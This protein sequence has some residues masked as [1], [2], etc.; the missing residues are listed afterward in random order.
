MPG[1][2]IVVVPLRAVASARRI[3]LGVQQACSVVIVFKHEMNMPA[4]LRGEIADNAAEI[5]QHRDFAELGDGVHGV[6]PQPVETVFVQP[7]QRILDGEGAHLRYPIIDRAAPGGLRLRE[8][9]RR[10]AAEIISLGTEVIVDHVEKH[11]QPAQMRF[12]DQRL[13][14]VGASIGAVRR[15]PQHA[16]IAPVAPAGEIRQRHQLQCGD[17]GCHEMIELVDHGAVGAFRCEG[18]DMG[19]EHDGF[20][21]RTPVPARGA[22]FVGGVIDHLAGAGDVIRLKRRGRIGYIDLVIDP[23][24]VTRAGLYAG[25]VAENQPSWPGSSG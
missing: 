16:V 25:D 10:I 9:T 3:L 15:I 1:V 19:F 22:P 13:E 2:M 24:L 7:V 14:I 17:S 11:H 20:L 12:I 5:V 4:G 21:P 6:E 8:E 18:A 23:E